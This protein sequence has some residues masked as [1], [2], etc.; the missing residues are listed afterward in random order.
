MDRYTRKDAERAF[1]RLL[2]AYG[3]RRA[4]SYCDVGGWTLDYVA[5]YGGCVIE[6]VTSP[7]GGITQPLGSGR[8]S[9]REFCQ[10]VNFAIRMK[11]L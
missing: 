11:N 6:E 10:Q 2:E 1:D 4:T 7:G 9:C 3:K 8:V 5:Q